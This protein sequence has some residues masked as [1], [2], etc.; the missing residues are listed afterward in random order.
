MGALLSTAR[1]FAINWIPGIGPGEQNDQ[2][3]NESQE[4]NH[5]HANSR[6]NLINQLLSTSTNRSNGLRFISK[7][8]TGLNDFQSI[9]FASNY[10]MA[11]RK[12]KNLIDQNQTFLF[13]DQ[14]DLGFILANKPVNFPYGIKPLDTPSDYIQSLV[15]IRKDTLKLI[16]LSDSVCYESAPTLNSELKINSAS[17]NSQKYSIEFV[18]D[19]DCDVE[20]KIH[21]FAT[22]K[23]LD[24]NTSDRKLVYS[25]SCLKYAKKCICFNSSIND[26]KPIIY[27]KGANITFKQPD[28]YFIPSDFPKSS[29]NFN[30]HTGYFP[31]VIECIPMDDSCRNKHSHVTLAYLDKFQTTINPNTESL[32][33]ASPISNQTELTTV[34]DKVDKNL[35]T[36]ALSVGCISQMVFNYQIKAIKQK[37]Y[38]DGIVY[39]LQ[40]IY[41][42]EKKPTDE[43]ASP[44]ISNE[45]QDT[46][47]TSSDLK[48]SDQEQELKGIECVICMCEVRDTLILPCRHLC[49]CKLCA[50]NLRVQ[51]NNCPI[52]RIPFIALVQIKLYRKRKS[53]EN[54]MLENLPILAMKDLNSPKD[55][56]VII[57]IENNKIVEPEIKDFQVKCENSISKKNKNRKKK[58]SEHYDKVNLFDVF[59]S[60]DD[61][62]SKKT[63]VKNNKIANDQ[64]EEIVLKCVNECENTF[65]GNVSEIDLNNVLNSMNNRDAKKSLSVNV[66][67]G[68][69]RLMNQKNKISRSHVDLR[70]SENLMNKKTQ[71]TTSFK[72]VQSQNSQRDTLTNNYTS[73]I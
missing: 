5:S 66:G 49:L 33:L 61:L 14:L 43:N 51:S 36:K 24:S 34:P 70:M 40:E 64:A 3:N 57:Q 37:Q 21:F 10:F 65:G 52:C 9:H 60:D 8:T 6:L 39:S 23:C 13:G 48:P 27:K 44:S 28:L 50:F 18:F 47:S 25:C 29:W 7:N 11:G 30:L 71:G 46:I 42:I 22:E 15:N 59:K 26:Q 38:I 12:F 45:S 17:Q 20:I 41:G 67:P 56:T 2:T 32:Q 35:G 19:C 31:V 69:E 68:N 54:K 4:I 72:C 53:D 1:S 16:K 62:A 63:K 58:I 55:S 73:N